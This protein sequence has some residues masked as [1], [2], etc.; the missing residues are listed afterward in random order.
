MFIY[1]QAN[2]T[3]MFKKYYEN[4][5]VPLPPNCK[6]K[7]VKM[8]LQT[9]EWK[10]FSNVNTTKKLNRLLLKHAPKN[11]Y[12]S[13]ASWA[14]TRRLE[15]P[16]FQAQRIVIGSELTVDVDANDFGNS[17]L[18][19]KIEA[20][21]IFHFLKEEHPEIRYGRAKRTGGGYHLTY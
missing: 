14:N 9:G 5:I 4:V 1:N 17:M 16:T 8:E 10:R 3:A 18:K 6:N 19:A 21:R 2:N 11:V 12:Y 15:H 7:Q 13:D 20:A